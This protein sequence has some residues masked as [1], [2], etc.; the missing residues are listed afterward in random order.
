VS[1][2][3]RGGF[4]RHPSLLN[5]HEHRDEAEVIAPIKGLQD[6]L[7]IRQE[8]RAIVVNVNV[9]PQSAHKKFILNTPGPWSQDWLDENGLIVRYRHGH[10][11]LEFKK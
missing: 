5:L 11:E 9:V 7:D 1:D 4:I 8:G 2:D 3:S 6:R 10:A